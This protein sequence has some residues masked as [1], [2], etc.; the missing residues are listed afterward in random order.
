[1]STIDNNG[2]RAQFWMFARGD[3]LRPITLEERFRSMA[4][5]RRPCNP[6]ESGSADARSPAVRAGDR[7]DTTHNPIAGHGA[8]PTR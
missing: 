1:M 2:G 4:T 7:P 3:A 6:L 5:A 8:R